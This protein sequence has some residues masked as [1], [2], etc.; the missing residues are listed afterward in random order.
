M[1]DD[2]P[3]VSWRRG[4]TASMARRFA[5]S[6][7]RAQACRRSPGAGA[8]G[9]N[10]RAVSWRARRSGAVPN[11][12][13]GVVRPLL[14][15][16]PQAQ[17]VG[18]GRA[19]AL[20]RRAFPAADGVAAASPPP[21]LG[22]PARIA[23]SGTASSTATVPRRSRR[24]SSASPA[25][26]CGEPSHEAR[27]GPAPGAAPRQSRSSSR[28]RSA[29][30]FHDLLDGEADR[31]AGLTARRSM[32]PVEIFGTPR[33]RARRAAC[34]PLPAPGGP[35]STT[36]VDVGVTDG[37]RSLF[38]RTVLTATEGADVSVRF[39]GAIDG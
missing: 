16:P 10:R 35:I 4:R 7:G 19:G 39:M 36:F 28:R 18:C 33:A 8:G 17:T 11:H 30:A 9:R 13:L 24:P 12:G 2:R 31:G 29:P 27:L 26:R 5:P 6:P 15:A 38:G 14:R 20:V 21:P 1:E 32:S 34:V 25:R 22:Q 23:V 37:R 3:R